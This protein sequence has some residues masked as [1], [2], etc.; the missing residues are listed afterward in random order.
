MENFKMEKEILQTAQQAIATAITTELTGYN[1]PL[2]NLVNKVISENED[3]LFALI[4]GEIKELISSGGF[5]NVLKSELQSKLAKVLINK[6]GGEFEKK[7]NELKQ[8][9]KTR[10]KITLAIDEIISSI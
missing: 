9:P 7:V 8:N 1:K 2:S 3:C 6:T 4:D 5:K 10:A